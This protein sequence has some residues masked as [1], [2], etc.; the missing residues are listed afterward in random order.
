MLTGWQVGGKAGW[1][2]GHGGGG[3]GRGAPVTTRRR[4]KDVI[5]A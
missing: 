3:S 1:G 2:S 5:R 4:D